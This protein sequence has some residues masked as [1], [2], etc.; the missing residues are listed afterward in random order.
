[1]MIFAQSFVPGC[2]C[3]GQAVNL[4]YEM[5]DFLVKSKNSS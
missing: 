1:M 2:I 4:L 5:A 3:R